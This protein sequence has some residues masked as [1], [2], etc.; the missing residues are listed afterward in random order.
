MQARLINLATDYMDFA[1][2]WSDWSWPIIPPDYL[3]PIGIIIEDGLTKYCAG[4]L[5]QMDAKICMIEWII[6]NKDAPKEER[7]KALDLLVT[8][9]TD[10]ARDRGFKSVF[11]A[12][13]T[14]RLIQRFESAGYGVSDKAMTHMIRRL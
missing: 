1:N 3:P 5:Y 11:T 9:L 10:A 4:W 6:S 2:W 8:A 13:K 7:S 14:P 12:I